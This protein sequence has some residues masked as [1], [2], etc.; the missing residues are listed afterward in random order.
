MIFFITKDSDNQRLVNFLKRNKIPFSMI[1]KLLR[2]KKIFINDNL[3]KENLTIKEGDKI[4][5]RTNIEILQEK[6]IQS[7]EKIAENFKKMIIYEDE[8]FLAIEKPDT[9]PVQLGSKVNFCIETMMNAYSKIFLNN[10]MLRIVHRLDKNT[11]GILLIAK[12]ISAARILTKGFK[13]KLIQKTYFAI[14]HNSPKKSSGK[15]ET[16]L[17][18]QKISGEELMVISENH[19]GDFAITKYNLIQKLDGNLCLLELSPLTGKTHQ[20]RVHTKFL[21]TPILGDQKY[22]I[23]KRD[24]KKHLYLHAQKIIINENLFGHEITIESEF[25]EYF[26]KLLTKSQSSNE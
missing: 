18:K 9:I 1:N 25:P 19:E 23:E 12:T 16:F 6:P 10:Q 2:L 14:C 3:C 7:A 26:K 8:E 20:L 5:I 11:S 24:K 4:E 21:K 17:K 13:E 22:Y 15:I